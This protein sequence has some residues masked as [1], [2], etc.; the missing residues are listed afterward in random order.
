M[1]HKF[2]VGEVVEYATRGG[3]A[4]LFTVMRQM[5]RE[6]QQIDL[7]YRIKSE[8]EGFER[9]VMECD[10]AAAAMPDPSSAVV[11]SLRR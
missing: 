11:L 9:N 4:A 3:R 7:M 10:L 6:L 8:R 2:A 5:P 1:S